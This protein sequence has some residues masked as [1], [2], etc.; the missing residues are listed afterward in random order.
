MSKANRWRYTTCRDAVPVWLRQAKPGPHAAR[1]FIA[2]R[3][4]DRLV[5]GM[6][7]KTPAADF[8]VTLGPD[9]IGKHVRTLRPPVFQ[10]TG[11]LYEHREAL[12]GTSTHLRS[13]ELRRPSTRERG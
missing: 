5:G 6:M 11:Q 7:Y 9:H 1:A 8:A 4:N 10:P 2:A 12:I 3:C 13:E